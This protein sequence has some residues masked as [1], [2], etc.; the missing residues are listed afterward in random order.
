MTTNT[1]PTDLKDFPEV[2]RSGLPE[3]PLPKPPAEKSKKRGII[4]AV[5][6][7]AIAG[8]T[9]YA[10]WRAGQPQAFTQ[11]N[12]QGKGKGRGRGGNG[13]GLGPV[14]VVTAKVKRADVPVYLDGLGNV[15][16]FYT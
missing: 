10:V 9:G 3:P 6:L 8:V 5:F 16:A 2:R 15:I 12:Q 14:P 11:P 4:W 7:V 1:T 13:G